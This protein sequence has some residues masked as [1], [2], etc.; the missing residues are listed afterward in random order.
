MVGDRC[1]GAGTVGDVLCSP[2]QGEGRR[3]EPGVPSNLNAPVFDAAGAVVL[4]LLL[5]NG[6]RTILQV[7]PSCRCFIRESAG[8]SPQSLGWGSSD[9]AKERLKSLR[10]DP[11][12]VRYAHVVQ[13]AA[14]AE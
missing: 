8:R 5:E 9:R 11:D 6:D 14:L 12:R 3:F 7:T 1:G 4:A 10:R 13:F 2:C